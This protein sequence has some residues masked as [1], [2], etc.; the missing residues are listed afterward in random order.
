MSREVY[1]PSEDTELLLRALREQEPDMLGLRVVEV[2]SGSGVI[3][4][5]MQDAGA[6][7]AAVDINPEATLATRTL[8]VSVLR[9]DLLS[10]LRGPFDIVVFNAPY[11]P[12]S[13]EERVE[14]WID[15]AFHGGEGGVEVSAR[16]AADLGRVLA[17]AGRAYL[18]V[19]NRADLDRLR[20]SVRGQG[21]HESSVATARFFFEQIAVWKLARPIA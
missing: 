4:R 13:D 7:V 2:G 15:H 5:A 8:G 16:F 12:S 1:P 17:P 9:G 21:L 11:L 14:G 18:V 3:A 6:R 10:A 20:T 19:S